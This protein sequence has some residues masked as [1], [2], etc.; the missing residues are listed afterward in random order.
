LTRSA[1]SS[2]FAATSPEVVVDEN[3][4]EKKV[5]TA[6]HEKENY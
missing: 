2:I 6:S 4:K 5:R 3:S 1:G